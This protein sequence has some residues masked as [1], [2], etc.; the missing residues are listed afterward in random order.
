MPDITII[1]YNEFLYNSK[2]EAQRQQVENDL[3]RGIKWRN[4]LWT[5]LAS[6][7]LKEIENSKVTVA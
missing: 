7:P 1:T 2:K 5:S 4:Y 6:L 3:E